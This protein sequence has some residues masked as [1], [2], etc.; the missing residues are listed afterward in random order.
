MTQ[1][2]PLV[3]NCTSLQRLGDL[4]FALG[5]EGPFCVGTTTKEDGK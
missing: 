4:P 1:V 3:M 2:Y 5:F